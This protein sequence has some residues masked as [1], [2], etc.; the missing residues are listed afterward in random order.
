MILIDEKKRMLEGGYGPGT[1]RAMA[2]LKTLGEA[3]E[4]EKMIRV[5]SAHI[6]PDMPTEYLE[7]MT[8]GV[9]KMRTM[10]SLMPC[11]DPVY[12]REKYAIV[13]KERIIGGVGLT[14]EKDYAKNLAILNYL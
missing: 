12:W 7:Q 2:F 11:L 6:L 1:Q 14:D 4:A 8:D 5:T 13:S 10:V 9:T 3:L